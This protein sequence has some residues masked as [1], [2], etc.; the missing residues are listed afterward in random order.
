MGAVAPMKA[1]REAAA[2]ASSLELASGSDA[3]TPQLGVRGADRCTPHETTA[4]CQRLSQADPRSGA[5][6]ETLAAAR[7]VAVA[8]RVLGSL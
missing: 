3:R 5:A 2:E 1:G 7:L 4:R 8:N 6:W